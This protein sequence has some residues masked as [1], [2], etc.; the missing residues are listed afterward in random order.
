M[1]ALIQNDKNRFAL[2]YAWG[3]VQECG[4]AAHARWYASHYAGLL[5]KRWETTCAWNLSICA[6]HQFTNAHGAGR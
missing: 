3:V 2:V 6:L 5:D 4:H 1:G